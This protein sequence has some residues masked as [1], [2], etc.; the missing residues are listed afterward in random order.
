MIWLGVVLTFMLMIVAFWLMVMQQ[1]QQLQ[2]L[3]G[4]TEQLSV[5]E[6]ANGS[7]DNIAR[8]VNTLDS[9]PVLGPAD[10]PVTIIAFE[11]FQCPFCQSQQVA[12]KQALSQYDGQ[13]RFVYR[14]FPIAAIHPDAQ[15]AA[16]AA[17]CAQDQGK[18]WEYHD[19]LF[20][21]QQRHSIPDLKGYAQS[22]GL[23]SIRFDR[24]LDDGVYTQEVLD[25]YQDGLAAGVTGTPTFFINGEKL[26]GVITLQGFNE[27]MNYF[28]NQ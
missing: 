5:D 15:K 14:D 19:V 27:I 6:N 10:A 17:Q 3:P 21:N 13:I 16:E 26:A 28:V 7:G 12:L 23:D 20:T 25:D 2:G 11:D 24:C 4:S 18:F 8:A 22:L 9:D 1:G